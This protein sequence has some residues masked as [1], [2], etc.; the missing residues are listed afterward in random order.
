LKILN[1]K[2]KKT[3][4]SAVFWILCRTSF[5]YCVNLPLLHRRRAGMAKPKVKGKEDGVAHWEFRL[6]D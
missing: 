6:V 5:C 1:R 3:A 2:K 4:C